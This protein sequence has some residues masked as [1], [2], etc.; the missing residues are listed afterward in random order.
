MYLCAQLES[1]VQLFC[2]LKDCSPP[3]SSVHEIFQVRLL[4]QIAIFFL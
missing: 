3:G 4:E 1:C 2:D